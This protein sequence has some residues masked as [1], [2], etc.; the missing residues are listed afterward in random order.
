MPARARTGFTVLEVLVVLTLIG[1]GS[2]LAFP[3][4]RRALDGWAVRTVRDAGI[5]AIHRARMEARRRGGA[6]LEFRADS[7]RA[8][9]R[10]GDS[11]LWRWT[12]PVDAG[13]E[14]VLARDRQ[15]DV[16]HFDARG[17][18]RVTSRT[19]RFTRGEASRALVISSRGRATR[20]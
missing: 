9:L 16:L 17:L 15:V 14:M 18:G 5:S 10:A 3:V 2:A 11:L 13:V 4:G 12:D 20:R 6:S 1:V 7:G 8:E 19:V